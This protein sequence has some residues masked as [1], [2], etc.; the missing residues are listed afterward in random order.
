MSPYLQRPLRTE[1]EVERARAELR[2][3]FEQSL[4]LLDGDTSVVPMV[5][6]GAP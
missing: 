4:R 3:R 5:R 6:K 2:A 1:A